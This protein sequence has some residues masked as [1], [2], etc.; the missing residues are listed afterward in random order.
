MPVL[1][2]NC[3]WNAPDNFQMP[4]ANTR[5]KT[6]PGDS[7]VAECA[8]CFTRL[9][10]NYSTTAHIGFAAKVEAIL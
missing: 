9:S 8:V 5:V 2:R 4:R 10:L 6:E 3:Q 7:P 1:F